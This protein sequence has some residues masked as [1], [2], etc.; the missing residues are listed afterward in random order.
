MKKKTAVIA[1]ALASCI[2][3][4]ATFTG[5]SLVSS[6]NKKDMEQ[7][8]VEV[9]VSRSDKFPAKLEDYRNAITTTSI[10][11]R[12][13]IS[14][15]LNVGYS[16]IQ[17]G[18]SYKDTFNLL[19][20]QL[21][22]NAV[23][24]Q[25]C[26]LELLSQSEDSKSLENFLAYE[27]DVERYEYLLGNEDDVLLAK[28]SLY[29]S[30][31]SAID[32][33]EKTIIDEEDEYTGSD[34]RTT[35]VNLNTEQDDYYPHGKD[36]GLDYYV[37][38]GY[39]GYLLSD[40]GIYQDDALDGTTRLTRLRAYNSFIKNLKNNYLVD[41][42]ED[43]TDIMSLDYIQNE[44]LTQLKS[45][46]VTKYFNDYEEELEEQL[47]GGDTS[48]IQYVYDELVKQQKRDYESTSDFETALGDMSS[49]SF[50]LYSPNTTDS[51]EF[52]D[53]KHGNYGF[54]YNIL[55][56]FDAIQS[57][58]LDSLSKIHSANEDDDYYYYERN[59]ILKNI[60]TVDQR[61]A[62]FNGATKY[63][64]DATE[65][66]IEG[67]Y[68]ANSDWLF[69]EDNLTDSGEGGRYKKLQAYTGS[70]P[71]NG[72]VYENENGSYTLLGNKLDIDG[73][74]KEFSAYINFVLG[75]GNNVEFYDSYNPENGNQVYYN[76]D[77]F[78]K[79]DDEDEIDYSKFVY[80]S[81]KV[82]FG[83]FNKAELMKEG[84]AQ[85]KAMS[86][87]NELQFA[88]TTD[89]GVLS[90]YIGYSVSAYDTNYIK[91]FEYAAK[92][93]VSNGEGSFT[94]CAGDYGW[95]LIYV[96]Y[97]FSVDGG[98]VYGEQPD[99]TKISVEGTFENQFFEMVKN[100]NLAKVSTTLRSR[101]IN[102]FNKDTSV[103]KYQ[104]RYQ[105]LLDLDD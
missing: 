89:T 102:D 94:V 93:A 62:W 103:T 83:D 13:L 101:I 55:L 81:G 49:S 21:V 80:A 71:Y 84:T 26:T 14:Y 3:L 105:D 48:Y 34:T 70:Y 15:F 44:Y 41:E 76:T 74:L 100:N 22:E 2:A 19:V 32:N 61:S 5:C 54:V 25:Y 67:Y 58:E 27:N 53:G 85:Y 7:V 28:Y 69:F 20:N 51:D 9:D 45:R 56:P 39:T 29:K 78:H 16:Y 52:T 50:I 8:I 33:Y 90:N 97:A 59:K 68:D 46:A 10:V 4:G 57:R 23:L 65:A 75:G 18:S 12:D 40:S 96:T 42:K 98:Y 91:E 36:G 82:N 38:T 24:T 88:Y 43:L 63:A 35:P 31:N 77:G 87:V 17:N 72:K 66:G 99:W 60:K 73:M 47:K 104:N 92:L 95:H 79:A 37:Y 86:A 6:N 1:A 11:K 30:L 64:F